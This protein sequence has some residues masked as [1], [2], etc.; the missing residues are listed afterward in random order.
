MLLPHSKEEVHLATHDVMSQ[1][2]NLLTDPRF[3]DNAYLFFDDDPQASPP[4]AMESIG[5]INTSKTYRE[6]YKILIEPE[7]KT[8]SGRQKVLLPYIF[9]LDGCVTGQFQNLAIEILKFTLGLFKAHIRNEAYAWRNV[10]LVK[11]V[12]VRKNQAEKISVTRVMLIV[13]I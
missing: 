1:T 13:V 9:Y 8:K 12:L 7:P 4:E 3:D 11:K 10:G 6:T 2:T 5:D